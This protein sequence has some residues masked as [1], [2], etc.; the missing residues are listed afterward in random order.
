VIS[1][2]NGLYGRTHRSE[3]DARH[4]SLRWLR[5]KLKTF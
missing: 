5:M 3:I 2:D 1:M 4:I